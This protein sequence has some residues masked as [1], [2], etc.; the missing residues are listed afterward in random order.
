MPECYIG[1]ILNSTSNTLSEAIQEAPASGK[2]MYTCCPWT[3]CL[4]TDP[5]GWECLELINCGT[6]PD[7]FKIQHG[8][9]NMGREIEIVCIITSVTSVSI[10]SD[11]TGWLLTQTNLP[12]G[13]EGESCNHHGGK[14]NVTAMKSE[15]AGCGGTA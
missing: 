8:I 9:T 13:Q 11:T 3:L 14:G 2:R 1:P 10:T 6:A 15:S 7:H 5:E 4:H 12:Y